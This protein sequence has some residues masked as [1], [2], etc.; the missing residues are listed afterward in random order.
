[1]G[2][3]C[4]RKRSIGR[5]RGR[6]RGR[7]ICQQ[8]CGA[9]RLERRRL[10]Q[11][12]AEIQLRDNKSGTNPTWARSEPEMVSRTGIFRVRAECQVD[13]V[14]R[15]SVRDCF[16]LMNLSQTA[17]NAGVDSHNTLKSVSLHK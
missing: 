13:D 5:V 7:S 12:M 17:F 14:R 11:Q 15:V 2:I 8:Q 6:E 9:S 3:G 16:I 1:M 10:C 4:Y